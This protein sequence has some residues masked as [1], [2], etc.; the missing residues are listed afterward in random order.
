MN[1]TLKDMKKIIKCE[2]LAIAYLETLAKYKGV[3]RR[4]EPRYELK[5]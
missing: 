5:K 2:Y 3:E 4:K 1:P